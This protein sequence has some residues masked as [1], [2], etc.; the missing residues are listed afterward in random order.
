MESIYNHR[1]TSRARAFADAAARR[2]QYSRNGRPLRLPGRLSLDLIMFPQR[3][4]PPI[5]P[6]RLPATV[7]R[8]RRGEDD[9]TSFPSRGVGEEEG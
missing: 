1:Y 5:L 9:D 6:P 7:G 3:L 2:E 4:F 8:Y